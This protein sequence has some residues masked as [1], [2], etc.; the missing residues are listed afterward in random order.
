M[1]IRTDFVTNSS[2]ANYTLLLRL[3]T[4]D[5]EKASAEF[6][7]SPDGAFTM[8]GEKCGAGITFTGSLHKTAEM[9]REGKAV[10]D[11]INNLCSGISIAKFDYEEE[12]VDEDD[13]FNDDLGFD[14]E[15]DEE[16]KA[17][18]SNQEGRIT[19]D[20]AGFPRTIARF[21]LDA[22][23]AGIIAENIRYIEVEKSVSG[24]G[25][26]AMW[27]E[28][29]IFNPYRKRF[30]KAKTEKEKTEIVEEAAAYILSKPELP[31][32]ANESETKMMRIVWA[33][34]KDS[35][36][37]AIHNVLDKKSKRRSKEYWMG[38]KTDFK[39]FDVKEETSESGSGFYVNG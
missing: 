9:I 18:L 8:D 32:K 5:E 11:I 1:K 4:K 39:T 30:E 14:D 26:S 37:E 29:N 23:K 28:M 7:V 27:I 31:V 38:E 15:E 22:R 16:L 19:G 6:T 36:R 35:L 33:G 24:S 10:D 12:E 17:E 21:K 2:S 25:D 20:G 13:D 34:S 3:V